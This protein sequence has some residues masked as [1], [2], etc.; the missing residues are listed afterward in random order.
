MLKRLFSVILIAGLAIIGQAQPPTQP[1]TDKLDEFLSVTARLNKFNG[2]ALVAK[3]GEILL[4]K[5]YGWRDAQR[6]VM[7]DENSI[8]QIGSVTKQFTSVIILYLEEQGKLSVQDNLSKYI[9]GYPNGDKIT[10]RH[11]LTHTSGIFNYTNDNAFMATEAVNP[12]A[13]EKLIAVFKDK[14]LDFEPGSQYRYSNSGYILLGYIIEKVSGKP[15][16]QMV[17]ELIFRPL[18][19]RNSGFDF[20]ALR[21]HGKSTGYFVLSNDTM[22]APIVDSSVSYAAGSIYSTAADLYKWHQSLFTEK[23]LRKSSL[24]KAFTPFRNKYGYGWVIDSI[25]NKRV[26]MH[27]GGIFGFTSD[28]WRAPADSVCIILLSNKPDELGTITRNLFSIIYGKPYAI[29]VERKAIKLPESILRQYIGEYELSSTF[30]IVIT[31][32]DGQLKGQPTGQGKFDLFAERE[33]FFFV[34]FVDAQLKFIRGADGKVEQFILQQGG[35]S[36]PAKKIK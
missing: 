19:M 8:F 12:I 1:V 7:H 24:Q 5:G 36:Q 20:K 17:R 4:H 33:D 30:K 18:Q 35:G 2:V 15:Y 16:E 26:I 9:P 28:M 21:S 29:P 22:P 11:L 25:E 23:L 32:E 6:R 14:P 27:N 13:A 31:L 34:K 10:I 3:D